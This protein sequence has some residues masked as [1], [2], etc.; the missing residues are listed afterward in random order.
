MSV[1]ARLVGRPEPTTGQLAVIG[2][3][4]LATGAGVCALVLSSEHFENRATFAVF[5]PLVGWSFIATGL[6]AWRRRPDSHFGVLMTWLGFAW[7]LGPLTA[8]GAPLLFT[9]GIPVGSVWAAVFVHVLM[10]FPSGRL[11]TRGQRSLV[12]AAYVLFGLG[13]LPALLFLK[14]DAI[15][16]CDGPC[17][18]NVFRVSH[19]TGVG[20]ALLAI[21]G[22]LTAAV[23]LLVVAMQVRRW[24][25]ARPPERRM[26]API[27]VAG[28]TAVGFAAVYS[29]TKLELFLW[30]AFSAIALTPV[31]FLAGLAGGDVVRSRRVRDFVAQLALTRAQ[32]DLRGALADALGDPSLTL[33]YWLPAERRWVDADGGPLELPPDDHAVTEIEHRG[34][35]VAAILHDPALA[36]HR[37]AVRAVGAAAGL[38]LENQRL[39][40][41]LLARLED[42]RASRVRLVEAT[43][44][45]RRR[46][47]RNLHDGAQSRLVALA[48]QLRMA[49]DRASEGSDTRLL[50]DGAIDELGTGLKELRELARGIHPAVL[51]ERGL[52]PALESLANR[53]GLPVML[54][55]TLPGRLP[56]AAETAAYYVVAEALTNVSKYARARHAV[57]RAQQVDGRVVI[58]VSDDGVGGADAAAGSGLTGLVDRLGALDGSLEVTSPPGRGTR[59]R[60]ELPVG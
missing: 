51:S 9:L 56:A 24:R 37:D 7:F 18:R 15:V 2:A 43:D 38:M 6:Y 58:E 50:L 36:E 40:A 32:E 42:L 14:S 11:T 27:F 46:L 60:A 48:L 30:V 26:L 41:E 19:E 20:E 5:G 3:A 49:R 33:A 12:L 28:A 13:F 10:S 23:L 45:E 39:D 4:A 21:V 54:D 29:A 57:V 22:V 1:A 16:G 17:P 44:A 55:V 34:R 31:A 8:F 35:R 47:E 53:A 59:L 52:A 25:R